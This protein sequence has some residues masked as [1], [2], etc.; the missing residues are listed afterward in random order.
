[1]NG[2]PITIAENYMLENKSLGSMSYEKVKNPSY[3]SKYMRMTSV[4]EGEV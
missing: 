1:M 4:G 2:M 3:N